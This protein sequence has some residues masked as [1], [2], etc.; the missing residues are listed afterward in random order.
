MNPFSASDRLSLW[1]SDRMNYMIVMSESRC[2]II[3]YHEI[4]WSVLYCNVIACELTRGRGLLC[5]VLWLD[6]DI[7]YNDGECLGITQS[8]YHNFPRQLTLFA[9]CNEGTV[10]FIP[11]YN[12]VLWSN[13]RSRFCEAPR[14]LEFFF[15]FPN[16]LRH[17]SKL[18]GFNGHL[19]FTILLLLRSSVATKIPLLEKLNCGPGRW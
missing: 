15:F 17:G 4:S 10:P 6:H 11:L 19:T 3:T 7:W 2:C 13:Y 5:Q 8:H 16:S 9:S 1:I 14:E 12:A 18:T